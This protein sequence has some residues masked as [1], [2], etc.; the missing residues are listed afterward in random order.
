MKRLTDTPYSKMNI[1][2]EAQKLKNYGI[3]STKEIPDT[4]TQEETKEIELQY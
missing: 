4:F 3:T 1:F 2:K